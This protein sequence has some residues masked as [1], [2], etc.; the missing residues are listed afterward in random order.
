[1]FDDVLK[2]RSGRVVALARAVLAATFLFAIWI[3]PTQPTHDVAETY[4]VLV[5]Y[6]ASSIAFTILVWNNWW[7]DAKL[8]TVAHIIDM[9]AFT[10]LVLW[11]AF[12]S[13][14][15]LLATPAPSSSFSSSWSFP[16]PFAGGGAK[17]R[18]LQWR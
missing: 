9:A 7:L 12:G 5:T 10:L 1:M 11:T 18:S 16:P 4:I 3:D 13:V 6:L 14:F 2:H 8:G 17:P 15:A